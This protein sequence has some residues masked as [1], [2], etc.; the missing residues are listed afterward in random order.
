MPTPSATPP[1]PDTDP[2]RPRRSGPG[3]HHRRSLAV[4]TALATLAVGCSALRAQ[5][6]DPARA[7]A[8][9]APPA[10]GTPAVQ[11]AQGQAA[12]APAAQLAQAQAAPAAQAAQA[13]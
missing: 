11:A 10:A 8:P 2:S 9:A 12:P 1:A 5:D 13:A 7:S 4:L 3:R 6:P